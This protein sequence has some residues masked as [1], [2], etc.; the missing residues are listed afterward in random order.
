M[1]VTTHEVLNQP[2]PLVNYNLFE[3][4][5]VLRESLKVAGGDWAIQRLRDLGQLE[6]VKN[7]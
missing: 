2:P 7:R 5:A 6:E 1:A 4:D 3:S